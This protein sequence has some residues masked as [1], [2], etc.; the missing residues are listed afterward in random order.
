[1]REG[2]KF[3]IFPYFD[4]ATYALVGSTALFV[5]IAYIIACLS[6]D[7]NSKHIFD[8]GSKT[9]CGRALNLI[10]LIICFFSA[11]LWVIITCVLWLPVSDL[12]LLMIRGKLTEAK[13]DLDLSYYGV[14]KDSSSPFNLSRAAFAMEANN[15]LVCFS[16]AMG[17]AIF[18][19]IGMIQLA[20]CTAMNYARLEELR[21]Y[22]MHRDESGSPST[23]VQ[24]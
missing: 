13:G 10:I 4:W 12:G 11:L 14:F 17:G 3:D 18:I 15:I 8:G 23:D 7:R 1:M 6:T 24:L 19:I 22:E 21:Y 2:F 5:I 9:K 16:I 20:V